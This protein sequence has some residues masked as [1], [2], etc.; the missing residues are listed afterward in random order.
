MILFLTHLEDRL[1]YGMSFRGVTFGIGALSS[2]ACK[3]QAKSL[4]SAMAAN[5][6]DSH[7]EDRVSHFCFRHQ[8]VLIPISGFSFWIR[9]QCCFQLQAKNHIS[10]MATNSSWYPCWRQTL[11]CMW[12]LQFKMELW[13]RQSH[14]C[15]LM[16]GRHAPNGLKHPKNA[17]LFDFGHWIRVLGYLGTRFP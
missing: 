12:G 17:R 2:D 1:T 11:I 13:L 10:I 7:F 16:F 3:L 8:L 4:I 15:V 14:V 9:A 6:K 5:T